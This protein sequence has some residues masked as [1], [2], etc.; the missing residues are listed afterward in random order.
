MTKK[1]GAKPKIKNGTEVDNRGTRFTAIGEPSGD[2]RADEPLGGVPGSE[3][4]PARLFLF[5]SASGQ[6]ADVLQGT[7]L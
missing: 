3:S 4:V 1:C 7:Q 5:G 6:R 2:D